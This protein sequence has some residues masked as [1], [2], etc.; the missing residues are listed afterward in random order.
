MDLAPTIAGRAGWPCV[1]Q[2]WSDCAVR[3][4]PGEL[5]PAEW[6]EETLG[7]RVPGSGGRGRRPSGSRRGGRGGHRARAVRRAG[8]PGRHRGSACSTRSRCRTCDWR[9]PDG[10]YPVR[11]D[12]ALFADAACA[13]ASARDE[14]GGGGRRR[15]PA[16]VADGWRRPRAWPGRR[17]VRRSVRGG[18]Q[19]GAFLVVS[20][21]GGVFMSDM[22]LEAAAGLGSIV[23]SPGGKASFRDWRSA[24]ARSRALRQRAEASGDASAFGSRRGRRGRRRAGV[25]RCGVRG[26]RRPAAHGGGAR[27][28]AR[29]G[30]GHG[31]HFRDARRRA[32]CDVFGCSFLNNAAAGG[33]TAARCTRGPREWVHHLRR[34]SSDKAARTRTRRRGV[35]GGGRVVSSSRLRRERRRGA[36]AVRAPEG[37]IGASVFSNN[38]AQSWG[39]GR[40]FRRPSRHGRT[41]GEC[42]T[43]SSAG[44]TRASRGRGVRRRE[45]ALLEQRARRHR[46]HRRR[47]GG[48]RAPGGVLVRVEHGRGAVRGVHVGDGVRARANTRPSP[49]RTSRRRCTCGRRSVVA[50]ADAERD[51]ALSGIVAPAD[52]VTDADQGEEEAS[53]EGAPTGPR[54]ASRR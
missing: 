32:A 35:R 36:G 40:A 51:D 25:R 3:F 15:R 9:W 42:R 21:V 48:R 24:A 22:T 45:V 53:A 37:L 1:E 52:F 18:R 19:E 20:E 39:R 7:V 23:R 44:T 54:R 46:Q 27:G 30:R 31:G 38:V 11:R 6:Y 41:K 47:G 29:G 8:K 33:A 4:A 28:G 26:E 34:T 16:G 43:R 5:T 2:A 10:G 49:S 13:T 50:E 14:A 12:L 17:G